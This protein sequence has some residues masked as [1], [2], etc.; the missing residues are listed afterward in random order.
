MFVNPSSTKGLKEYIHTFSLNISIGDYQIVEKIPIY[1]P[2]ETDQNNPH[3]FVKNGR[4]THLANPPQQYL[5]RS[6]GKSFYPHTSKF[7]TDLESDLKE[8]IRDTIQYGKITIPTLASRIRVSRSLAS[9]LLKRVLESTKDYIKGHTCFQT[10]VQRN[11]VLFV[12]ETFITIG[13]KTW[14]L[15]VVISGDNH[16]MALKLA[17]HRDE[18]TLYEIIENCANRLVFGLWLLVSDGLMAYKGI[19]KSL[20]IKLNHPLVHVRHIHKPNYHD[21]QMDHYEKVGMDLVISSADF[22][23]D[24]FLEDGGFIAYV[25][26][27]KERLEKLK[28][29]RKAGVKNRSKEE[30]LEEKQKKLNPSKPKGRPKG[31]T[32][33]KNAGSPQ[34]FIH[35]K[36]D[37]CVKTIWNSSTAVASAL[38]VVLEQFTG[39]YITTNL[40]EKEFSV[41]KELLCF[42]GRRSAEHWLDLLAAYYAVRED[43]DLLEKVLENLSISPTTIRHTIQGLI[44]AEIDG[45][46]VKS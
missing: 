13:H 28:R 33:E 40:I 22:W 2:N 15:I 21:I 36:K 46:G 38:N 6:C 4:D 18:K 5:C 20:A 16:V 29:G 26:E 27:K 14:Y 30:I 11:S 9:H 45:M 41:L 24:I 17:E 1:C 43:P 42:R 8:I 12:D 44:T 35:K 7:I 37:G 31:S 23:N 19:A 3:Y 10:K 39:Q 32:K 34:V 25:K